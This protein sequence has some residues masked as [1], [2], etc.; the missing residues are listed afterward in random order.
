MRM[1][2]DGIGGWSYTLNRQEAAERREADKRFARAEAANAAE[3]A[4][5]EAERRAEIAREEA[6]FEDAMAAA[7]RGGK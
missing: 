1:V 7:E 2:N 6:E 5:G 3:W 4:E